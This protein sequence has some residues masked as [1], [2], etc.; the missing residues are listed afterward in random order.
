VILTKG[1]AIETAG[2]LAVIRETELLEKYPS[3]LVEKPRPS[4]CK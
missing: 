2:I 4:A 1:P 3:P